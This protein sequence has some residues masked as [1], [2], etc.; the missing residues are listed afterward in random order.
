MKR[1]VRQAAVA[2][3]FYPSQPDQ[4]RRLVAQLLGGAHPPDDDRTTPKAIIAPHAG[5]RYSGPI[6]ATA[7]AALAP[8]KGIVTRVIVAGPAH[9]HPVGG[10][11]V[12]SATAFATPL[13]PVTVDEEARRQALGVA[14]VVVDDRAHAAEHSVEVHLP[15]VIA[16]LGD[17]A[18]LPLVVGRSGGRVLADVL[19][20]L[21]GG[22]E[23]RIVIST[24][25]SHYLDAAVARPLDARTAAAIC[26]LE[27]PGPEEACGAAAV[28]GMVHAARRHELDV[29]LLDLRNSG[30]LCGDTT[31]VVGYGAFALSAP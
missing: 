25:L 28:G 30:D 19:D 9:F 16:A 3:H 1:H 22:P 20:V 2:G 29:R 17:V 8:A 23:T 12:S 10:V 7:Y 24:D 27:C 13:G 21:W 26:R 15:F 5:Y 4:L 14:G 18:I 6:A 11:A 31:R